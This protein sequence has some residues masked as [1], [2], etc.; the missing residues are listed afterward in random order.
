MRGILA[1]LKE[2]LLDYLKVIAMNPEQL[3]ETPAARRFRQFF[4]ER[5]IVEGKRGALLM[6]LT[7]RGLSPAEGQ[8]EPSASAPTQPCSTNA[9]CVLRRRARSP[10][11]SAGPAH[12]LAIQGT[13][14]G[15]SQMSSQSAG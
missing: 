1:V 13:G 7:A 10:R 14:R 6:L 5:G 15:E 9:S 8:R 3:P 12:S 4:E 11:C 2:P